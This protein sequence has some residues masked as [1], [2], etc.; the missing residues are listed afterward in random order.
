METINVDL[1]NCYGIHS[2]SHSFDTSRG[3]AF[4]IYAPNGVMKSSFATVFAD[5]AASRTPSD[6][7]YSELATS[8]SIVD[9][10]GSDIAPDRILVAEP[11]METFASQR[12]ATLMADR[13]LRSE[14]ER[15]VEDLE[16]KALAAL[17]GLGEAAG[18]RKGPTFRRDVATALSIAFGLDPQATHSSLLR[19]NVLLGEQPDPGLGGIRYR[20]V[21]NPQVESFLSASETNRQ[22]VEYVERYEQLIETSTYFRR[23][24]F[25]HTNA[26]AVRRSLSDQGFFKASHTVSL[27]ARDK[28]KIELGTPEQLDEAIDAEKQRILADPELS[29]RF[30]VIDKAITANVQLRD[31]RTYLG[32]HREL[33]PEL[34]NSDMLR[35]KLWLA[36]AFTVQERMEAFA[37][38]YRQVT[39]DLDGVVERAKAQGTRWQAVLSIFKDRFS[40]P[41]E[42][43]VGNQSDVMLK[44]EAPKFAFTFKDRGQSREV[45]HSR[46]MEVLSTGERRALYLLNIIFDIEAR[47][48]ELGDTILVLDDVADSFDYA[49]K[50][51]IVEYLRDILRSGNFIM[52]ILTHNFDFFRTVQ[53]RLDVHR[54]HNCLMATKNNEGV[55]IQRAE[56][57]NP[58]RTW[59]QN[60]DNR[61]ML[62]AMIPMARNLVEYTRGEDSDEYATLTALLHRKTETDEITLT[63][64]AEVFKNVLGAEI[65]GGSERIVSL[66]M[67][68]AV[69]SGKDGNPINLESK[70]VLAIAIRLC[71]EEIMIARTG[72][73]SSVGSGRR[74]QT[75]ELFDLYKDK[76]PSDVE[77][78]ALLERVMLMTPE[79]IHLNSFMYEPILDMSN[80]HL[81]SLLEDLQA[82]AAR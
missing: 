12:T 71:A 56:H 6:R 39:E 4:L 30:E 52:F 51:A 76:F 34:V 66:I 42:I 10:T 41:F 74:G 72:G 57:L 81:K 31:F 75:R 73:L 78:I 45:A 26:A 67:E 7:I 17:D 54:E 32:N 68:Q 64:L 77:P 21:F 58:F 37:S 38:T 47:K 18:L 8:F 1:T 28:T 27:A 33:V 11:Y 24:V 19:L 50:Y 53:S 80:E 5:I 36:Y 82:F 13:G 20:E 49:N 2:L 3:R 23:G 62:I 29:K 22:L 60:L 43:E 44:S 79:I 65:P 25:N 55:I 15:L 70:V 69:A 48:E 61:R 35:R 9:E 63:R 40:V 46:L 59:R 16:V 14:Y